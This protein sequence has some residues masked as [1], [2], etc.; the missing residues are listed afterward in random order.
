MLGSKHIPKA[1]IHLYDL[2]QALGAKPTFQAWINNFIIPISNDPNSNAVGLQKLEDFPFECRD[3]YP[4][5]TMLAAFLACWLSGFTLPSLRSETIHLGTFFLAG[6][7]TQ[8]QIYDLATP[9]L[10]HLYRQLWHI[11]NAKK[12]GQLLVSKKATNNPALKK[13]LAKKCLLEPIE[14][15]LDDLFLSK[16][17]ELLDRFTKDLFV[18]FIQSDKTID[19]RQPEGMRSY[20]VKDGLIHSVELFA[21]ESSAQHG[22]TTFASL[23]DLESFMSSLPSTKDIYNLFDNGVFVK[24]SSFL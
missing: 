5:N 14:N 21:D 19:P 22:P 7:M 18:D 10:A 6:K 20:L 11:S 23:D 3:D 24:G 2:I 4:H 17:Y 16:F 1:T 9:I 8:G 15:E 12:L 13:S